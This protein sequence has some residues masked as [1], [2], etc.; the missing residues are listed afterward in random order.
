MI[1]DRD[2]AWAL[3]TEYTK[4]ESLLKHALGAEAALRAYAARFG[5]DVPLWGVTG[6]L[7]D[8]D[9]ERWPA[10][11]DHTFRGAEILAA[12]GFPEPLIYAIR[13]HNELQSGRAAARKN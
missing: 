2:V 13:A 6:L 5:E 11:A 1:A 3:L 9:Y 12:R 7:H 4:S 10:L 8:F